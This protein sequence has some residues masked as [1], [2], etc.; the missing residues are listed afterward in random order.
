VFGGV[1]HYG[2][3][4]QEGPL[5]PEEARKRRRRRK[6]LHLCKNLETVTR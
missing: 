3:R 5:H 1:A 2:V 6:E 4:V